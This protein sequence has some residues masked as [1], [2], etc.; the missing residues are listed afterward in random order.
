MFVSVVNPQ[1]AYG[2]QSVANSFLCYTLRTTNSDFYIQIRILGNYV[3]QGYETPLYTGKKVN[4]AET[5]KCDT[6]EDGLSGMLSATAT[7]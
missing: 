3:F 5:N 4:L 2:E 6:Y 7:I 1:A